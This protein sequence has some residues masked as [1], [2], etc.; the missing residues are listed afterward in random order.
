MTLFTSLKMHNRNSNHKFDT[1][2]FGQMTQEKP[3][4]GNP[5]E[6]DLLFLSSDLKKDTYS[7]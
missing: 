5:V 7:E 2:I 3:T 4:R 1:D 6:I